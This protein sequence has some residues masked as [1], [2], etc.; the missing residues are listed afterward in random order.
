MKRTLSVIVV[1]LTTMVALAFGSGTAFAGTSV[2]VDSTNGSAQSQFQDVGEH[3]YACDT[4][5]DG[6]RAVAIAQWTSGG[7][8]RSAE[9]QDTDGANNNCA[10][11]AN[12]DITDGTS[13]TIWA[14]ARNGAT[15]ALQFCAAK[16]GRA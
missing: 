2:I 8:A 1:V 16:T 15:G 7:V 9:V 11:H 5:S 14:C 13:V 10:G 4:K 3:L 6:L 12:L